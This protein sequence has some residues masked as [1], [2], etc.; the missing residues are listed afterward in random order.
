MVA[1]YKLKKY[2][3]VEK[4]KTYEKILYKPWHPNY[5]GKT[6]NTSI[7]KNSRVYIYLLT[8]PRLWDAICYYTKA[9]P[10]CIHPQANTD[11]EERILHSVDK[12]THGSSIVL[13]SPA[14]RASKCNC[15]PLGDFVHL[16]Q[17]TF[18]TSLY[19]PLGWIHQG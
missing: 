14:A 3:S 17:N 12:I 11:C 16:V 4:V 5:L 6:K 8:C 19:L 10:P 2:H 18:L 1:G 9:L 13:R 7:Q 15:P